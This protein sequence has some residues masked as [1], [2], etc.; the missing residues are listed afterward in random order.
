MLDGDVTDIVEAASLSLNPDHIDIYSASWGPDDDGKTVDGPAKMAKEAF[1]NG[2]T[3]VGARA[4]ARTHTRTEARAHTHTE[5]RAFR[6]VL[7]CHSW[8]LV[9]LARKN[10]NILLIILKWREII[11]WGCCIKKMQYL[12]LIRTMHKFK[13][14]LITTPPS[15]QT[16]LGSK[17]ERFNICL[18]IGQRR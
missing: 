18:G 15:S 14:I 16:L 13:L 8:R 2:I 12:Y 3:K 7:I 1:I 6:V 5:A 17:R 4:H 9:E 10:I 11:R